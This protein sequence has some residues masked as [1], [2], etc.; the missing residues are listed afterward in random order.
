MHFTSSHCTVWSLQQC[1]GHPVTLQC[2]RSSNTFHILSLYSQFTPAVHLASCHSRVWPLQPCTWHPLALQCYHSSRALDIPSLYSVITPAVH[3]TSC[4]STVCSF[5]QCTSHLVN[6]QCV[7][8]SST[9][10]P[11]TLH[12][13]H[14]SRELGILSLY[15]LFTPSVHLG[16]SHS[17]V[18]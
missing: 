17:T 15:S 6:I 9:P 18:C 12:G 16:S 11:F 13:V 5:Q 14:S 3:W 8:A 7:H 1:T 2:V 10:H 4:H